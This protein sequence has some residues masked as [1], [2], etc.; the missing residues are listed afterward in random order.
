[1]SV[2]DSA[3]RKDLLKI[4]VTALLALF[5]LP[6]LSYFFIQHVS[7]RWDADF[8]AAMQR[9]FD[10]GGANRLS[11]D[12]RQRSLAILRAVPP[13]RVC[14]SKE[15]EL[16]A[17][18][19]GVCTDYSRFWQFNM[20]RKVSLAC[21]LGGA[22]TLLASLA[23]GALAFV[24]RR[25]QYL[26]FLLGWR[27]LTLVSAL[28]VVAQSALAVWLSF[29]L[30]AY[31]FE[32]YS[33]KLILLVAI[34]AAVAVFVAVQAIFKRPPQ[35]TGM[36][37]VVLGSKDA[38]VLWEHLRRLAK[39]LD[40]RMPDQIVAG[41]DSNF[42][43]TEAPLVVGE[44][45]LS[46]RSLYVSLPLL[47]QL[48]RTEADA[49]LVHELAHLRGG[50]AASS[51]ALGPLLVRYDQ[52]CAVVASGF[53]FLAFYL[54]RMYRVIFEFALRRDSRAR[55]FLAD[56]TAAELVSGEA[57]GRA[58]IKV[59]AYARFRAEIE[60]K[61]FAQ[62]QQLGASLGIAERVAA[63]LAP[64]AMSEYFLD[65]MRSAS[66]PHPFDSHPPL[67]E[68][69]NN[70]GYQVSEVEFGRI[71]ADQ[72]AHTWVNFVE[73]A[74]AIEQALWAAY[75]QGFAAVHEQSLAYRME[76]A[77]EAELAIVLK[78]FPPLEFALH[79]GKRIV[80]NHAGLV[81]PG[82]EEVLSWD[83]VNNLKYEDGIGGDVLQIVHPEKGWL[84]A[85]TSKIKLPGIRK[86]RDG[87]KG[88]IGHY[89]QRHQIMRA[90]M[91]ARTM[92]GSTLDQAGG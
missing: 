18:R 68:R 81:L 67:V 41:I 86:Q 13:S 17:Y 74:E 87:F 5:L 4:F 46:G 91:A 31:F 2:N 34:A 47:R 24:N 63:G 66:M 79:G 38:P 9:S 92:A 85:K 25:A 36:D 73:A 90:E 39:Q 11:A 30:T 42:F 6:L 35:E 52:Y 21:L 45:R 56:R 14:D 40:T 72:P 61:L 37:G 59:V 29:W 53:A 71:A 76:P 43:V 62:E 33:V 22:F 51:A 80:I 60:G 28:E 69:M 44:R 50:D 75:E 49:V 55:E 23:L 78:Y 26:S 82:K 7:A 27:L 10:Q 83:S 88:A 32:L 57:I 20:A 1:M 70:V 15:S 77:N 89:W 12:D 84:G 3:L 16:A 64:Y 48:D 58:L 8:V 19:E 65:A 54:M